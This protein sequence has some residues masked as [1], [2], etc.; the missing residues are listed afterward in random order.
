MINE[1]PNLFSAF[2]RIGARRDTGGVLKNYKAPKIMT[3]DK[4]GLS[5]DMAKELDDVKWDDI[6]FGWDKMIPADQLAEVNA[7][8]ENK[9]LNAYTPEQAAKDAPR[10]VSLKPYSASY[11]RAGGS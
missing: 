6:N 9:Q 2:R 10:R 5:W 8:A 1:R 3:D 11:F 7:E 4:T